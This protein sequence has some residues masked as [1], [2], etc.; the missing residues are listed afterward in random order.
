ILHFKKIKDI[1]EIQIH[2]RVQAIRDYHGKDC[3][4]LSFKKGDTI[5]IYHKLT[6]KRE[7][8]WAGSVRLICPPLFQFSPP[9]W[10][11][12]RIHFTVCPIQIESDFFCMDENG[13]VIDSSHLDSNDDEKIPNHNSKATQSPPYTDDTNAESPS[14][15]V[16]ADFPV[17]AQEAD[18]TLT[19][20]DESKNAVDAAAGTREEVQGG[21]ASAPWLRSSVTGWLGL[22][23][24]E[25][26]GTHTRGEKKDERKEI[27]AESSFAS[28]VTGWLGLGGQGKIDN[29][30]KK[31]EAERE[32]DDFLASTMIGWLGFGGKE[33]TDQSA[34]KEK[35]EERD[36]DEEQQP[37]ENFISRRMSLDL[38][39][40]R[41]SKQEE[42][43]PSWFDM[44]IRDILRFSKEKSGIDESTGSGF[45]EAKEDE[46]LE[47]T[48]GS[49]NVNALTEEVKTEISIESKV[50][51]SP[52]SQ[53]VPS[54][55]ELV[56]G[57]TVPM[58]A[59]TDSSKDSVS[60]EGAGQ[61]DISPQSKSDGNSQAVGGIT[62]VVNS[63]FQLGS[64]EEEEDVLHDNKNE[65]KILDGE[66]SAEMEKGDHQ[67]STLIE[68]LGSN[69]F[70]G[71]LT[72]FDNS[73]DEDGKREIE[74]TA[75]IPYQ[76]YNTDTSVKIGASSGNHESEGNDEERDLPRKEIV[77][78]QTDESA[79]RVGGSTETQPV[80]SS[81][82]AEEDKTLTPYSEETSA[83]RSDFLSIT[84]NTT[85]AET[86]EEADVHLVEGSPLEIRSSHLTSQSTVSVSED[87]SEEDKTPTYTSDST[88]QVE[89]DADQNSA[90]PHMELTDA[91]MLKE[92]ENN[93]K[94]H[95]QPA[96]T[97]TTKLKK[98]ILMT[99]AEK[100]EQE[101]TEKIKGEE[102]VNTLD[103]QQEVEEEKQVEVVLSKGE[104][105]LQEAE[106]NNE[107]EKPEDIHVVKKE[108]KQEAVEG[109][110]AIEK[111]EEETEDKET[112]G[113]EEKVKKEIQEEEV[114][115][116]KEEDTPEVEEEEKM[117]DEKKLQLSHHFNAEVQRL[118][119]KLHIMTEMYQ[120]NELKLH[121]LLTVEEKE[122]LQKEE[123]LNKADKNIALAMEELNNYRQR[124]AEMEEELNKTKHSYQTQISEHEK[125]AHNNWVSRTPTILRVVLEL[126]DTQFKLDTL[127]KD[128]FA[129]DSL[130]RPMPFREK[131]PYGPSPLGRPAS[132][133][134]AF[135]SS[136]TL[137]DGPTRLSPRVW[138]PP[139]PGMLFPPRVP[140]GGLPLPPTSHHPLPMRPPLPEG[141]P[142]PSMDGI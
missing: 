123:K 86:H 26:P 52:K 66:G 30:V 70:Q 139:R 1:K 73:I 67:I 51:E 32:T 132:E 98:E 68:D 19:Q 38:E 118:Q 114:G 57:S 124:A 99:E 7:D 84:D 121:R 142:P 126:T 97:E 40:N 64:E 14:G 75:E 59:D 108:E 18:S 11:W 23:L 71:F 136:P 92:T 44:G 39:G 49:E 22:T 47:Q 48:A 79:E 82:K 113:E 6:G 88:T 89:D 91:H 107:E 54:E 83:D 25:E 102:E 45:K 4:F 46:T 37:A 33:R 15:S 2:Y 9:L 105:I 13:Y 24:M 72:Q 104:E 78:W 140:P 137:M 69:T 134:R 53:S 28:S 129:L 10:L 16:P 122:R 125:K 42:T 101:K 93:A 85:E 120:E 116:F 94:E 36:S 117:G 119:Q 62:S 100:V 106:E 8:L 138:V 141:L 61:E 87:V 103:K 29:A 3:R 110:N 65:M 55:V 130:T 21:S 17:S 41:L 58:T 133:T 34:K 135:L 127:D 96:Q 50:E 31:K 115:Q 111:Q 90:S 131:S 56:P 5:Y 43:P 74:E 35:K 81:G 20:D 76:T 112:Q 27:Q 12:G 63:L 77:T 60:I 128:P 95:L 109:I 80:M